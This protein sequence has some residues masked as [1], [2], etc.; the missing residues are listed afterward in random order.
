MKAR[1]HV[2]LKDGVLDPQGEAVRH[3]LGGMGFSGVES[4]RQGKVIE[5]DLADGTGEDTVRDM[6]EKLLANT[7]I[8][9]Y[10]IEML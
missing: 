1:V 8:E 9:S 2:M 3:A 5:L 7:V 6:C 10:R 4:V